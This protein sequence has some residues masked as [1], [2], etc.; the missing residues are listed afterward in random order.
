M[1]CEWWN[2]SIWCNVG[3]AVVKKKERWGGY[4]TRISRLVH[5]LLSGYTFLPPF[6]NFQCIEI[7]A[8]LDCFHHSDMKFSPIFAFFQF[9]F[10]L[11]GIRFFFFF[12]SR[13]HYWKIECWD[14][15]K[16]SFIVCSSYF[17]YHILKAVC[18]FQQ[19][20]VSSL[21]Q[22]LRILNYAYSLPGNKLVDVQHFWT[23]FKV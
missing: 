5:F 13:V 17:P 23:C 12:F 20:N 21:F 10:Y 19:T 18:K 7:I 15:I 6:T 2:E 11:Q 22:T 16:S 4:V 14:F 3:R 1:S 9:Q 8:Y